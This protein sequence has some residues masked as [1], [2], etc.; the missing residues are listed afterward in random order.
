VED[1]YSYK[2]GFR[3]GTDGTGK[4]APLRLRAG[5]SIGQAFVLGHTC[6]GAYYA[7]YDQADAYPD[8]ETGRCTAISTQYVIEAIPAFVVEAATR[9]VNEDLDEAGFRR[10]DPG[11]GEQKSGGE[12]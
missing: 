8:P 10:G 11:Y 12:R 3:T 9:S 4:L 7:L 5:S 1:L 6:E 2:Y